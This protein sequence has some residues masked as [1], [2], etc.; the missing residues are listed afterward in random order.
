MPRRIIHLDMDAFYAAIE[1]RDFP[2]LR[3]KPLIVGGDRIRGVVATASYEARPYG[4]HSAMP[5]AQ[6]LKLCPHAV[7]V[8]PRRERYVEVSRQIF[9]ILRTFTPLVEPLS[10]DEAFLDVTASEQ[11]FGPAV[12][13]ARQIKT[14][15][16][17]ETK[18]T[19]SAGVAS[20]KFVAKIASDLRKPDG[21]VEVSE[22]EVLAFLHPLPVT[23]IW[24]VGRVTA[25]T[26]H[27]LGIHTIG[28]LSRLSRETLVHHFGAHGEH[29]LQLAQGID[30]RPVDPAQAI[31]SIGEEETFATDLSRDTD[32]HAALLRYAQ[33]VARRLRTR[34]LVGRTITVKVKLAVRL[35]EGQFRSYTRSYTLSAPIND[36]QEIY[37]AA[38][39]LFAAV[40]RRGQK[41]RLAGIYASGL[42]SATST[43]Q[44]SLFSQPQIQSDKRRHLGQLI[45][46]LTARYGEGVIRFG[47]TSSTGK[48]RQRDPTALRKEELLD[49]LT[50]AKKSR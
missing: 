19:A 27:G 49:P 17:G 50:T 47:E 43:Q 39:S 44:L 9:A 29:L 35:G 28:D 20:T 13:I 10:L 14:R 6:A 40:P 8:P 24:G 2:E 3:G 12:S 46:E 45:D 26:L 38:L 16:Q 36:A 23:R 11:L 41:V 37:R 42:E 31:K 4:I 1:Q 7:V 30:P 22:A 5:M 18:L 25:R 32:V 48:L 15:I 21:L 34:G 33:T